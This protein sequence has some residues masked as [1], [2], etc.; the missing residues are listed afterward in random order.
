VALIKLF[1]HPI[2]AILLDECLLQRFGKADGMNEN[3]ALKILL[4]SGAALI[5]SWISP[6]PIELT[7][8]S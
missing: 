7:Q 8:L 3:T 5:P 6:V 4:A 1:H 2:R